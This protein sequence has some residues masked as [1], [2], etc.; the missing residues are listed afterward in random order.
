MLVQV[1]SD[2]IVWYDDVRYYV[3]NSLFQYAAARNGSQTHQATLPDLL[4]VFCSLA[5]HGS[6]WT[7]PIESVQWLQG[8]F[9][10]MSLHGYPHYCKVYSVAPLV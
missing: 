6:S 4:E 8:N 7:V 2:F 1:L 9:Y 3:V 5:E 10:G